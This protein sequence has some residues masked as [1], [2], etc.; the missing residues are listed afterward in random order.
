MII[1]TLDQSSR[2]HALSSRLEQAFAFLKNMTD[3]VAVQRHD[4]DGDNVFALVQSYETSPVETRLYEVHRKYLDVQY[5]HRGEELIY[6]KPLAELTG[7][8]MAY[9]AEKDAA[10]YAYDGQGVPVALRAGQFSILHPSDG[11]IPACSLQG[12]TAVLKV[13]VKVLID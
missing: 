2:Y 9:D 4:I 11:H 7:E 5:I 8:T 6:W 12:N 3:E 13:V 10:L 1:D